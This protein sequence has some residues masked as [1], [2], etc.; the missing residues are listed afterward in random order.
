MLQPRRGAKGLPVGGQE[1]IAEGIAQ[2][3]IDMKQ[4]KDG[5]GSPE[6]QKVAEG[7]A[8]KEI[9]MSLRKAGPEPSAEEQGLAEGI[10]KKEIAIDTGDAETTQSWFGRK[11]AKPAPQPSTP[12]VDTLPPLF[13]FLKASCNLTLQ[14]GCNVLHILQK[15][16]AG[17]LR[18]PVVWRFY[19][20]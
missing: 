6:A 18:A 15:S 9:D 8:Q 11:K 20:S 5:R 19:R 14:P 12:K 13:C 2:K 7:I 4:G 16:Q 10:A 3:E 1:G 17:D